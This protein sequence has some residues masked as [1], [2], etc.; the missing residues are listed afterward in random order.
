MI[1]DSFDDAFC[2]QAHLGDEARVSV[3]VQKNLCFSCS[4]DFVTEKGSKDVCLAAQT[5]SICLIDDL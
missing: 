2:R 1:G 3:I 4:R 5:L